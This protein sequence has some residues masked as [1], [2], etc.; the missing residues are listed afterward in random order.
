MHSECS[1]HGVRHDV[2]RDD[3]VDPV[4]VDLRDWGDCRGERSGA[5]VKEDAWSGSVG[6]LQP[7]DTI[8]VVD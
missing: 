2:H 4:A 7:N 5:L 3:A 8:V 1:S 6:Q